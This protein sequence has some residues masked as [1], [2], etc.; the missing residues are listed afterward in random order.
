MLLDKALVLL[1]LLGRSLLCCQ[2]WLLPLRWCVFVGVRSCGAHGAR[3]NMSIVSTHKGTPHASCSDV[4]SQHSLHV[5]KHSNNKKKK[6]KGKEEE[7]GEGRKGRRGKEEKKK[8][9][10]EEEKKKKKKKKKKN[11]NKKKKKNKNKKNKKKKKNKNSK[12]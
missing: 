8:R 9:E 10:E 11:K 12:Q 1:P 7:D 5:S 6:E 3:K 2:D 4:N